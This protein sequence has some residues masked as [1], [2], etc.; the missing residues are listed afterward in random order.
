MS[1]I[2]H[3][4]TDFSTSDWYGWQGAG[5]LRRAQ[6]VADALI[7]AGVAAEAISVRGLGK[8]VPIASN[9]TAEG[10]TQNRRVATVIYSE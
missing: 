10:R 6:A 4:L 2:L 7:G 8:S 9:Q 3:N 5:Q 1:V